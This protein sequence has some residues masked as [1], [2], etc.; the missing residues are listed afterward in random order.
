MYRTTM[1]IKG[2]LIEIFEKLKIIG[3][4]TIVVYKITIVKIVIESKL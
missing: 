3:E 2:F 1:I 4:F